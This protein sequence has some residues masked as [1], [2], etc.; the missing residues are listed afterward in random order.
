MKRHDF[1][2]TATHA[3]NI[4]LKEILKKGVLTVIRIVVHLTSSGGYT[5]SRACVRTST[6][7]SSSPF[8]KTSLIPS[9]L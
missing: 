8:F 4:R 6:G 2:Q 1:G 9:S 3:D 5:K 7:Y